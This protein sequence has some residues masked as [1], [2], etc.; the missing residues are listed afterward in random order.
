TRRSSDLRALEREQRF[1]DSALA[2]ESPELWNEVCA[3]APVDR[4]AG[5]TAV[6]RSQQEVYQLLLQEVVRPDVIS[7]YSFSDSL[8]RRSQIQQEAAVLY[9]NGDLVFRSWLTPDFI[10][11][12][13]SSVPEYAGV[14]TAIFGS[15]WVIMV[16]LLFSFPIGV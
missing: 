14:R 7:V 10:R 1:Y 2:F 12:P 9:P 13:Q 4:P 11:N 8:L 15:I 16:T 3:V 5:C 6:P